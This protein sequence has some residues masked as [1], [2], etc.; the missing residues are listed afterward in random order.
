MVDMIC[1]DQVILSIVKLGIAF[2]L[3]SINNVF[4]TACFLENIYIISVSELEKRKSESKSCLR[5][6][7][8]HFSSAPL[9]NCWIPRD[10][11]MIFLF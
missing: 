2:D 3:K 9:I 5:N 4:K 11:N 10:R 7:V 6:T 8:S 1:F